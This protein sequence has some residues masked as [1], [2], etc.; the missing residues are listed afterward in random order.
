[1]SRWFRMY[2]ELLDDP[3]VQRLPGEDFKAWVNILCL[4]S[5]KDGRL[6]PLED[7]GFALRLDPRKAT[8]LIGRL[9]SAGLLDREDDRFSPHGWNARQYKSDVSTGRVKQFRERKKVVPRNDDETFHATAPDTET[10][11]ERSVDKSTG[12]EAPPSDPDK[13]FW[14]SA[15]AY[16][17]KSKAGMIGKWVKDFGRDRTAAAIAQAQVERAVDPVAYIEAILRKPVLIAVGSDGW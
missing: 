16:L 13:V 8:A 15:K 2:D 4:A 14:D 11:T 6:P 3:K 12:A 9:V 1:M 10:D 5:R 7:I 17:G